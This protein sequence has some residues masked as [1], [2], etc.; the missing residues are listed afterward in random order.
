VQKKLVGS[1]LLLALA[2]PVSNLLTYP[3]FISESNAIRTGFKSDQDLI[4]N[5][6][7]LR[8]LSPILPFERMSITD[9]HDLANSSTQEVLAKVNKIVILVNEKTYHCGPDKS[10]N[11]LQVVGEF[12]SPEIFNEEG[13]LDF[14]YLQCGF[15][16]QRNYLLIEIL[17]SY[18]FTVKLIGLQGHVVGS[19]LIKGQEY[20]VD[21]DFGIGP[22]PL[23]KRLN[24]TFISDQY[25]KVVEK[26]S[27]LDTIV[28]G[29]TIA[30]DDRVYE[31]SR[32]RELQ[33]SQEKILNFLNFILTFGTLIIISYFFRI[34]N[35]RIRRYKYWR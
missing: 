4:S 30:E 2:I 18:G 19:V 27:Q 34:S 6:F 23:S 8:N 17:E 10:Q 20:F 7:K 33:E 35:Q 15:C 26:K 11:I 12:F 13:L 31:L 28:F 9:H 16:H 25:K 24:A 1:F 3:I 14:R 29:Y 22:F 21:S 5:P 32:M